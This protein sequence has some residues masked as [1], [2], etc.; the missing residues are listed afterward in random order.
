MLSVLLYSGEFLGIC[1][2]DPERKLQYGSVKPLVFF[3]GQVSPFSR[4]PCSSFQIVSDQTADS[5]ERFP[6]WY[7]TTAIHILCMRACHGHPSEADAEL[8]RHLAVL[9]HVWKRGLD[10]VTLGT[11]KAAIPISFPSDPTNR[12]LFFRAES[13]E[14]AFSLGTLRIPQKSTGNP[15]SI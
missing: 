2:H 13:N 11:A 1:R 3:P 5:W 14:T 9:M 6:S 8:E 12:I 7:S 10:L 4:L 15:F